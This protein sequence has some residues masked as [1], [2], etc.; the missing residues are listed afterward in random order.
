MCARHGQALVGKLS[1]EEKLDL[2]TVNTMARSIP[3]LNVKGFKWDATCIHGG[4]FHGATVGPHA[5]NQVRIELNCMPPFSQMCLIAGIL[6]RQPTDRSASALNFE[7][8]SHR[9]G[10]D[11]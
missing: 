11:V 6:P 3:R 10:R 5:I 9:A 2:W 4:P 8:L 1:L 7:L